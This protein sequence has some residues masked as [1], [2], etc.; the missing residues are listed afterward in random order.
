MWRL[1]CHYLFLI[2]LSFDA[3]GR[4]CFVIVAFPGY[5][6]IYFSIM[7]YVYC[8]DRAFLPSIICLGR[9]RIACRYKFNL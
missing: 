6:H 3:S 4:L 5:P 9:L 8:Y 1:F 2:S 7:S